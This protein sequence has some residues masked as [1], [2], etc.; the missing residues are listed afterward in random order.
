MS[1]DGVG[2]AAAADGVSAS[3]ARTLQ[4]VRQ[5]R[6]LTVNALAKSSGVSRAMIGKI[7]RGEVQPTAALLGRLSGAL[8]MALSELVAR[9][10]NGPVP[11]LARA[12]EQSLWVDPGTGYRRREVS[13]VTGGPVHL[14]E[15]ELPPGAQVPYPVEAYTFSHHVIWVLDGTLDFREGDVDHV[16]RAGDCLELGE[17]APCTYR[18]SAASPCRYLVVVSRRGG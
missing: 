16:L 15:V 18:N 4:Q 11:R 17:P 3:L 2:A 6:G 5:V 12:G 8:G 14:V 13:P 10:E 9:A 7:E 1:H